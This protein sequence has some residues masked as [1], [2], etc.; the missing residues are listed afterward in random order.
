MINIQNISIRIGSSSLLED[1]KLFIAKG[2]KAGLIGPN[3]TGKTTLF[4][5]ILG[6]QD[7]T[8]AIDMPKDVRLV[9]VAQHINDLDKSPL[10]HVLE[11]DKERTELLK[12]LENPDISPEE[13]GDIYDRLLAIDAYSAEARAATIL[14]GLGFDTEMQN[15]PLNNLSGGWQMRVALAA[16]LFVPS[17]VLMLDEPT[18]H[19]D[20]E[21]SLWLEDYLIRYAGTIILISHDRNF[22][23]HVCNHII[24][25][26]GKKLEL[27][28]GNYDTFQKTRA[29]KLELL[30][31]NAAKIEE[32]RKHL[33]SFVDRFKAKATKAKQAQSRIKMI[34]KLEEVA[35]LP[36]DPET[37]FNFPE[38]ADIAPPL[39]KIEKAS[40]GYGDNVVL[41]NLNIMLN[42]MDKIAI[43]GKNG[44]GKSTL[45]KV[46]SEK[47]PLMSGYFYRSPKLEVAYFAQHLLDDAIDKTETPFDHVARRMR[48]LGKDPLRKNVL[49]HL[50][51]Y[52]IV[53]CAD[54]LCGNISGG[55]QSR[56]MIA[57][58][59][60]SAPNLLIMD[61]PTNHLD[62]DGRDALIEALNV[63]EG[64]VIL[65]THDFHLLEATADTLWLVD[66]HEC[67][68]FAG[69]LNDYRDFL[70]KGESDESLSKKSSSKDSKSG[71][72]DKNTP[73][74]KV[75]N[76]LEKDLAELNQSR[77]ALENKMMK[78]GNLLAIQKELET[79]DAEIAA[80]ETKLLDKMM[81]QE[82]AEQAS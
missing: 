68:E 66:N 82:E 26:S 11:S 80:L 40:A 71:K 76:K 58:I 21:A 75:I 42:P 17:D 29:L 51:R 28:K 5:A 52:G 47:L 63:Y 34:A 8:G 57:L 67:K 64:T 1:A 14:Q 62:I 3:G 39:L 38:P 13:M 74:D 25:L 6:E 16:A 81:E 49:A 27:Y 73:L 33:Q 37:V 36:K 19:L 77:S 23:N 22:L 65:I 4:R 12:R 61:E 32:K 18:N 10:V 48:Q 72:K 60:L 70:L 7:F 43:L 56:L 31:K 50:A 2:Q 20:L 79:L 30:A 69:D 59:C 55:Q 35:L 9:S 53:S 24:H 54:T 44:N 78:G 45:A 15:Q 41:R 46:I